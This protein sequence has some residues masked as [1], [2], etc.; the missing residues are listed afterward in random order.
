MQFTI[1]SAAFMATAVMAGAHVEQSTVYATTAV[2]ITSCAPYVT[3]CPAQSTVTSLTSYPVVPSA[4]P[5][6]YSN[7]T[8][9]TKPSENSGASATIPP[10]APSISVLTIESCVPTVIYSTITVQPSAPPATYV[11]GVPAPSATGVIPILNNVTSPS[12]SQTPSVFT[13]SAA[14]LQASAAFAV[15]AGLVAVVLA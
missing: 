8:I 12:A 15:V 7:S 9:T 5:V 13:G 14:G 2:T 1:A 11:P 10:A 6:N 3:D 4:A